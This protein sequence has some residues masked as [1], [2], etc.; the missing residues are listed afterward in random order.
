VLV[1]G[2]AYKAGIDDTRESPSLDIMTTLERRGARVEYSDPFVPR[3]EFSG[4]KLI[5]VPLTP[6]R[7]RRFDCVVIATAHRPFPYSMVV[8]HARGIVDTRNV[9]KGRRSKKIVRL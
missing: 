2:V 8:R 3:L 7:L 9:L 5:S 4:R 6:A 1:L